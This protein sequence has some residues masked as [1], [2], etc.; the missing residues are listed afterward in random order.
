MLSSRDFVIL[1]LGLIGSAILTI[2]LES[3]NYFSK[4]FEAI[5]LLILIIVVVSAIIT[6]FYS[7]LREVDNELKKQDKR[8]KSFSEILKRSEDLINIK[9]DIKT[10]KNKIKWQ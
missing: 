4:G 10:I 2:I 8:L 9:A 5:D 3:K 7:K 1:L 6:I